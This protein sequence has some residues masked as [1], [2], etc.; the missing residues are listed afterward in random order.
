MQAITSG[1]LGPLE[2][3]GELTSTTLRSCGRTLPLAYR[4]L[5]YGEYFATLLAIRLG[6]TDF[7]AGLGICPPLILDEPFDHLDE[8]CAAQVWQLLS[9]IATERQVIVATHDSLLLSQLGVTPDLLLDSA[10]SHPLT[11]SAV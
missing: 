9:R 4:P 3:T 2:A 7:L 10:G 5:S 11:I 8:S 6:S 1:Q